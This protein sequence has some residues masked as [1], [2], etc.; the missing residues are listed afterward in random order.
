MFE[1]FVRGVWG[2]VLNL[3]ED[4]NRSKNPRL[5]LTLD[6]DDHEDPAIVLREIEVRQLI[7]SLEDWLEREGLER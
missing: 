6:P 3:R 2:S 1:D 5:I 7:S 4:A